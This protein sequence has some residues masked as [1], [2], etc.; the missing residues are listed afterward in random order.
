LYIK[1]CVI[2]VK[3][4]EIEVGCGLK[5]LDLVPTSLLYMKDS[6]VIIDSNVLYD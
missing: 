6:V 3:D 2:V 5:T 4:L 1:D